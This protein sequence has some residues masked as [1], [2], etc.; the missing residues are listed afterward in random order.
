MSSHRGPHPQDEEL[1]AASHLSTLRAAVYDLSWLRTRGYG[2]SAA[3]KAVGDRYRL[4]SR[5]R[6]AVARSACTDTE[7]AHRL[8]RQRRIGA[9]QGQWV[10]VDAFNVVIS[11]EGLLGG[12]YLFVGRDGA[13]RD[14][15]AVRNTYRLVEETRA[16]IRWVCRLA[17]AEGLA[18]ILWHLDEHVSNVGRLKETLAECA[19]DD[20]GWSIHIHEKVDA[21]L[22][23][24]PHPVA[25]SDS[26]ILDSVD[27]WC[28]LEREV[29]RHRPGDVHLLDLRPPQDLRNPGRTVSVV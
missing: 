29:K 5:Q 8:V 6:D 19:P 20:L 25:T 27:A 4:R 28:S 16:A 11:M 9:L 1:F 23:K 17:V 12:A 21:H 13:V 10:A 7:R 2:D 22:A 14:V 18:G 24:G 26:E 3:L 15:E